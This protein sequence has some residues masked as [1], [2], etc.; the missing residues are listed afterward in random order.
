[1][2]RTDHSELIAVLRS[3]D[4]IEDTA[5]SDLLEMHD[6]TSLNLHQAPRLLEFVQEYASMATGEDVRVTDNGA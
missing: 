6:S 3:Q 1:M 5:A 4:T 2:A